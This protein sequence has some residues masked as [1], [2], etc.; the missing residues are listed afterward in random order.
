MLPSKIGIVFEPEES[1]LASDNPHLVR[2]DALL[3][4]NLENLGLG[5]SLVPLSNLVS[6]THSLYQQFGGHLNPSLAT[7]DLTSLRVLAAL[8]DVS[9]QVTK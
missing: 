8:H 1:D 6:V 4:E 5:Q 2:D 7:V 3:V 9:L